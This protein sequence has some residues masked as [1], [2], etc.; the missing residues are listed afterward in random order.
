MNRFRI[1][2]IRHSKRSGFG[3]LGILLIVMSCLSSWYGQATI[4][5]QATPGPATAP[6]SDAN[7]R[8]V[9]EKIIEEISAIRSRLGGGVA[10][11][12]KGILPN[13][14][15]SN[16][17]ESL[18]AFTSQQLQTEFES[19]L[20]KLATQLDSGSPRAVSTLTPPSQQTLGS[21]GPVD[22]N[23]LGQPPKI[24]VHLRHAARNLETAAAALEEAERFSQAD[25]L[26]ESARQLWIE[27]RRPNVRQSPARTTVSNP[28]TPSTNR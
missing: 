15:T 9:D 25:R 27:A 14:A 22:I 1:L 5:K 3:R 23:R 20:R 21:V 4:A 16:A 26:R 11:Q 19:E 13:S 8:P 6:T 18:G 12:L 28:E 2:P 17:Q 10:D 24:S 7:L